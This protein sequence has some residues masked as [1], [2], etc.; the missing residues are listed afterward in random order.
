MKKLKLLLTAVALSC[1]IPAM[2]QPT[3]GDW[4]VEL[5][6]NAISDNDFDGGGFSVTGTLG[7]FYTD[8][9][10]ISLRQNVG[11]NAPSDAPDTW[12]GFTAIAVDWN[13]QLGQF[14]PFVGANIGY[15]Y[16]ERRDESWFAAPEVGVK[17][18]VHE[19]TYI[20]ARGEYQWFFD[21]VRRADNSFDEGN[22]VLALGIGFNI[23]G[24]R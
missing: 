3:A 6:G 22:F 4:E 11:L 5:G 12:S 24:N 9:L 10:E 2:A 8:N 21:K 14:V 16:A 19:K 23:G 18:Y 13:F 1:A 17:Y 7:Y 20:F 15:S